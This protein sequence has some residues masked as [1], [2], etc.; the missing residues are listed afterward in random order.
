MATSWPNLSLKPI[1]LRR[2]AYLRR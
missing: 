1:R 2:T